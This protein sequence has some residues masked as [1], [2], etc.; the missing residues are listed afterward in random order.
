MVSTSKDCEGEVLVAQTNGSVSSLVI[1]STFF[2]PKVYAKASAVHA[3]L[4][5]IES[6]Y[7]QHASH[8]QLI[9]SEFLYLP[10]SKGGLQVMFIEAHLKKQRML[11]LQQYSD[12]STA[13]P[14]GHW[15]LPG[16]E[17]LK[18]VLPAFG[19]TKALYILTI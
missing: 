1:Y 18:H 19:P 5:C 6:K 16:N 4:V 2:G 10:R 15:T 17:L 7:Q 11:F 14:S 9:K 8:M 12:F 13:Q 3:E